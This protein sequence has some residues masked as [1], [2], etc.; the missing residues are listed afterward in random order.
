MELEKRTAL[1]SFS[2]VKLLYLK[3]EV[4]EKHP[5]IQPSQVVDQLLVTR[6]LQYSSLLQ[7]YQQCYV[8]HNVLISILHSMVDDCFCCIS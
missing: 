4:Q 3:T 1:H 5:A 7:L 2:K 6:F 8:I